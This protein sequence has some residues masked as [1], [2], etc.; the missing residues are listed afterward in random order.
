[1]SP[2][3]SA[4]LHHLQSYGN[5]TALDPYWTS[6]MAGST[7]FDLAFWG[8][9][10]VMGITTIGASL[11]CF[12]LDFMPSLRKYKIQPT[13]LPTLASYWKCLKLALLNQAVVHA[14]VHLTLLYL[15]GNRPI[16]SG[17]LPLPTLA[18][19]VCEFALFMVCEDCLF[20][21]SHRFLHWKKV[22]KYVHKVHH[23]Y[24]APFGLA[25][26]YTH[27]VEEFLSMMAAM[28]G[29]LLFGS[30]I[31]CLWIWLS[32]LL[33]ET[34]ESHSGYESPTLLG[35]RYFL[36]FMSCPLRH[37]YHHEKLEG[38]YGSTIAFW[39]WI[40]GTDAPFRAL[41][42][43]KAARGEYGWFDLFDRFSSVKIRKLKEY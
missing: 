11:L 16:F 39:D 40:C 32:F 13:R 41:Q 18:T 27:P 25:A 42:H 4:A 24:T 3:A 9:A 34:V 28:T 29:P 14:P 37:D 7:S 6:L 21:W 22:Y 8:T 43:A 26:I 10:N 2:N 1:M 17:A 20:Y 31:V 15:W 12:A 30:H 36:P 23:E 19:I 5:L 33:L 38:N 35:L